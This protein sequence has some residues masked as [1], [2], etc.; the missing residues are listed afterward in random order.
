MS[1]Q[2]IKQY[3]NIFETFDSSEHGLDTNEANYRLKKYGQNE[4]ARKK[5]QPILIRFLK[6]YQD[7]MMLLLILATVVAVFSG[8]LTDA[9][10]IGLVLLINGLIS[11]IQKY[12]AEKAVEAL[13]K[14]VS[15]QTRV[16]RNHQQNLINTAELVPGD[17][18]ILEE[19]DSIAADAV[20]FQSNEFEVSE[21]ILTGE[22]F[23]V[24][25]E[26]FDY[27]AKGEF[28]TINNLVFM[29]TSVSRG[30]AKAIV[31][32]TGMETEFGKIADLTQETKQDDT[33]LEKEMNKIGAFS[34]KL[35]LV[36][37]VL[38]FAFE[39]I[40]HQRG[41]VNNLLFVS[42]IAVAAVPEGLL[43]VIT[44]ALALGVQ[45]LSAKK[46]IVKQLSSVETLGATT[47][48][49]TDKTGTLT[50]NE[51][52]VSKGYFDDYLIEFQGIGYDPKGKIII[53]NNKEEVIELFSS[54]IT[55]EFQKKNPAI[56]I[57]LKYLSLASQLCNN[58]SLTF[59]NNH[60][61]IIG[62]PTE[63]GLLVMS[64]KINSGQEISWSES[65]EEI[66]ELPFDSRRKI[67]SKIF[68]DKK[69]SKYFVFTK[70]A[71]DLLLNHCDERLHGGKNV[72]LTKNI[73][74]D[75]LK[76][77]E[78]FNQNALRTIALAYREI[79][80]KHLEEIINLKD[81]NQKTVLVEKK[82]TFIGLAGLS[83]PPRED[84]EAA[85]KLTK[86]AGL[87]SYIITGDHGFTTAAI[88]KKIGLIEE[89]KPYQIITGADLD[90]MSDQELQSLFKKP[91]LDIIFSRSKP[92]QKL[93]IVS[94]LKA[95]NEIVA[96]TGDGVNDAP[97]LKRADIGVA[98]GISGSDVSKE[99]ANMVLMDDSYSTIITAI[100]EGRTIF[101]NLK[102]FIFYI[103]SSNIGEVFTIFISL[104]IGLE[105]PLT[106]VLILTINLATDLLP[107][108]ALGIEP[109]EKDIMEKPPRST[110]EKV[111][112][113]QMIKRIMATGSLIGIIMI[114]LYLYKLFTN[115][116]NFGSTISGTLLT[117]ISSIIFITMVFI[118]V[119]NSFN[120]KFENKSIFRNN[121]FNN[122]KLLLANLI[123]IVIAISIVEIPFLQNIF[124][125]TS[126]QIHDWLIIISCCILFTFITEFSKII[127]TKKN[128]DLA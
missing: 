6:E 13:R 51:M 36:I 103:F 77:N 96:V 11:F 107:A 66:H 120:A 106:A 8:D 123:S 21:A 128:A 35:T 121:P 90:N 99:T 95:N 24:S 56:G 43:A 29:G 46:A 117:E 76:I 41:L 116:W 74:T 37:A 108:L 44:I 115:N 69:T 126:I 109:S 88:A 104:V 19:G 113:K 39:Y 100:K 112:N 92:E 81:F 57:G 110:S 5:A 127:F 124:Q 17:I 18:I 67:M 72:I 70:G 79:P 58:S 23:P 2:P 47:V 14:L 15:P 78:E 86:Q 38:I 64:K 62:D 9:V 26:A 61:G 101:N 31:T 85:I 49:C 119:A 111:M 105:S 53:T 45:R 97:A 50:K 30:N 65:L 33:P 122:S 91:E 20:I 87:K 42:S 60:Y 7:P 68:F 82:L 16:L 34:A 80:A 94:L 52:T 4:I 27:K 55:P 25:K 54:D 114:G 73:K 75:L 10:V 102:K 40:V 1:E 83:D 89:G 98:M 28:T 3:Q 48:I 12:K 32:K 22:S 59:K 63:G 84:V 71:P 118:Q 125:T 93:R